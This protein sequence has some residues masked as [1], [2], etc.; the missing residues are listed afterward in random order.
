MVNVHYVFLLFYSARDKTKDLGCKFLLVVTQSWLT[1]FVIE[2][3][4]AQQSTVLLCA[5]FICSG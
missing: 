1:L 5:F 2:K 4:A 3:I